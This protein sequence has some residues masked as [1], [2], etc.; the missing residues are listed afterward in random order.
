MKYD[1]LLEAIDEIRRE[2]DLELSS[3]RDRCVLVIDT[4]P[5][6]YED[7]GKETFKHLWRQSQ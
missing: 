4:Y 3:F 5:T 6:L 1:A 2:Q 7:C